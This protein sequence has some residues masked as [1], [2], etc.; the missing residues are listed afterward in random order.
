MNNEEKI[1]SLIT[2]M[3]AD[4]ATKAD[5]AEIKADMVTN[6]TLTEKMAEIDARFTKQSA[7]FDKKLSK[8][9]VEIIR[10]V[11]VIIENIFIPRFNLLTEAIQNIR[12]QL[13][14]R[15]KYDEM[16]DVINS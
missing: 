2:E 8:Q 9:Q 15:S 14:P 1:L 6:S 4:M 10:G 5:L 11:Q 16:A 13:V 3:R 12:E 7:D